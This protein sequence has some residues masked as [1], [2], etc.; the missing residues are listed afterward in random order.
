[1]INLKMLS[2]SRYL[3][4]LEIPPEVSADVDVSEVYQQY[5]QLITEFTLV[6]KESEDIKNS[7]YS[8][9]ELRYVTLLQNSG[10]LLY[11][12]SQVDYSTAELR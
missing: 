6:H 5:E 1:M 4:K 8:T 12:R 11:S 7:G 2:G 9:A 3:V 10:R